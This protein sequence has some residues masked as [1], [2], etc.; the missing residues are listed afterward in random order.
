[1]R[2]FH[3][4]AERDNGHGRSAST[5]RSDSVTESAGR[6]DSVTDSNSRSAANGRLWQESD[7]QPYGK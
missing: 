4:S 2:L 7:D 6:T 5:G 3:D 1:M